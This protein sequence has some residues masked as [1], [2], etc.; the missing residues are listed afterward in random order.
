MPDDI[1]LVDVG[2]TT[3]KLFYLEWGSEGYS[4]GGRAHAPTTVEKPTEDVMQ[5]VYAAF[6]QLKDGGSLPEGITQPEDGT[7]LAT[8]SAGGG[9]QLLVV[10]LVEKISA[11]SARKAALGAG[12]ILLDTIAQND[13]RSW[14]ERINRIRELR[15]DLI[16]FSGGFE[17]E[18]SQP[19]VSMAECVKRAVQS[20]TYPDDYRLPV[21]FAGN[22]E[23]RP[24]INE[25]LDLDH[26]ALEF[27]D[28]VRP[29]PGEEKTEPLSE[30]I[31]QNF[32]E[33]VMQQAPG[34]GGLWEMVSGDILPTPSAVG[35][36]IQSYANAEKRDVMLVDMGGATT[37]VFTVKEGHLHRTVSANLGMSY[38]LRNALV[39]TGMGQ[40]MGWLGEDFESEVV[41]DY[42][43]NKM[44]H[45]SHLPETEAEL[46]VEQ[47]MAR[48]VVALAL[49]DHIRAAPAVVRQAGVLPSMDERI[50]NRVERTL[51]VSEVDVI[52]G[53]GGYFAHSGSLR[54]RALTMIDSIN[55]TGITTL[56]VDPLF[57]SP[58]MGVLRGMLGDEQTSGLF[59]ELA[60]CELGLLIRPETPRDLSIR[61]Q[62]GSQREFPRGDI[63]FESLGSDDRIA[64]ILGMSISSSGIKPPTQPQENCFNLIVDLRERSQRLEA[65]EIRFSDFPYEL[66]YEETEVSYRI[67]LGED[68]EIKVEC[69]EKVKPDTTLALARDRVTFPWFVFPCPTLKIKPRQ[70]PEAMLKE[71]GDIVEKGEVIAKTDVSMTVHEYKSP[72]RG[73]IVDVSERSGRVIIEERLDESQKTVNV[74]A[75][76][77]VTPNEVQKHLQV[78]KGDRVL[79]E[80]VI[81]VEHPD[82]LIQLFSRKV[83]APLSGTVTE[84]AGGE[85]TIS[86]QG[87]RRRVAAQTHGTVE[88][89]DRRFVDVS[90]YGWKI[91]G[92]FGV[93]RR[94]A[95]VLHFV[96]EESAENL[97]SE[98]GNIIAVCPQPLTMAMLQTVRDSAVVGMVCPSATGAVLEDYVEG[99]VNIGVA[100]NKTLPV[101]L[102][103][104]S[105]FGQRGSVPQ[106]VLRILKRHQKRPAVLDGTTQIRAGVVRPHLYLPG[107]PASGQ[108]EKG[109]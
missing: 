30:A 100:G 108:P 26:V 34:Y 43:N 36:I 12:G 105:G 77:G 89:I 19:L 61:L 76:L 88:Q 106:C 11:E 64:D 52:I 97:P 68:P 1:F 49:Q 13:G 8:S 109:Y 29:R 42:I 28:N 65:E 7:W 21:V 5:G 18:S 40:V 74:A 72:V 4:L 85:V 102:C 71:V 90:G 22:T 86:R 79:Q 38:S 63:Y 31:E 46:R 81:A 14:V 75:E 96:D 94:V 103:M 78:E 87:P 82:R 25:I 35:R 101:S 56:A 3:T 66:P 23:A 69:G 70:L 41:E 59:E 80:S 44:C 15:P 67:P 98:S 20:K 95:G 17:S 53:S 51:D 48:E 54:D 57:I 60:L 62:G 55:P 99:T 10:G 93:G 6:D 84:V 83:Q 2:S 27:V 47:A 39:R 107:N 9:L 32:M 37:D 58:H 24:L 73:E 50:K 16:V 104:L 91:T 45:P 33:H 92:A